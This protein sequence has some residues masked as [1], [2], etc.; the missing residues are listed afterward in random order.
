MT[1]KNR[2]APN[3]CCTC[4]GKHTTQN[5]AK[6]RKTAKHR[7]AVNEQFNAKCAEFNTLMLKINN[8]L[9]KIEK[10]PLLCILF[11]KMTTH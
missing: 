5:R 10:D 1:Q 6:H 11:T 2:N 9:D 3:V 4:G 8:T 7:D